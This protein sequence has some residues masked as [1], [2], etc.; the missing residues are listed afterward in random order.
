MSVVI[1]PG[2]EEIREEALLSWPSRA[3]GDRY[4]TCNSAIR[5][6]DT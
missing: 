6:R 4:A 2:A 3:G 1:L 5:R